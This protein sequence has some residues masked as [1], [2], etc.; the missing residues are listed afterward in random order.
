MTEAAAAAAAVAEAAS[1][2]SSSSHPLASLAAIDTAMSL[3]RDSLAP[4]SIVDEGLKEAMARVAKSEWE[5]RDTTRDTFRPATRNVLEQAELENIRVREVDKQAYGQ[6]QIQNLN[7]KQAQEQERR[8]LDR[9]RE[10]QRE[11][12]LET[13]KRAREQREVD[14]EAY[15]T[16]IRI[17][18]REQERRGLDRD[19]PRSIC[20]EERQLL[21]LEREALER[22]AKRQREASELTLPQLK[23]KLVTLGVELG[24]Q[25]KDAPRSMINLDPDP[26]PSPSPSPRPNPNPN[27]LPGAR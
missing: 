19:P 26:S 14:K 7:L 11:L 21:T 25:V 4:L 1:S 27:P 8:R 17:S 5:V 10:R 22:V 12:E 24:V 23:E 3:A 2:S 15:E 6:I 18:R 16:Q 13:L 20:E 9:E